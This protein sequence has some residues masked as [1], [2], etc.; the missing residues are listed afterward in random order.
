MSSV[1]PEA[2]AAGLAVLARGGNAVDAAVTTAATLGVTEPY[3]AG[4]GGGG[5]LVYY[6]AKTR[7]VSTIDG[8]ETAPASMPTDAFTNPATG[9][10]YAFNELV[11]S[12]LSVGVPGTL[13]TWQLALDRWGTSS[14]ARAIEPARQVAQRGFVVDDTFRSQTLDNAARLRAFT[15][16]R[17]L[18]LPNGDAP[19]VGSVFRNPTW[20]TPTG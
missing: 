20:S 16:S 13:A 15:S 10:P 3:S 7:R 18:W 11:T 5:Y 19:V 2:S 1:D 6:D 17:D 9:A 8:R 12:G 14:L 4:I